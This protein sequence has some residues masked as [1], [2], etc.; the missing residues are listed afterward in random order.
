MNKIYRNI[1]AAASAL[2][3]LS[4]TGCVNEDSPCPDNDDPGQGMSIQFTVVTHNPGQGAGAQSQTDAPSAAPALNGASRADDCNGDQTGSPAENFIDMSTCQFFLFDGSGTV[5]RRIFPEETSKNETSY[6]WYQFKAE[7]VEPYFDNAIKSGKLTVDFYIMVIANSKSLDGQEIA[8]TPG[9]TT[10]ADIAA[11]RRTFVQPEGYNDPNHDYEFFPWEPDIANK[12]LI[13]MAGIQKFTVST[14]DLAASTYDTPVSLSPEMAGGIPVDAPKDI[15]MLRA[16]AKIEV[17]DKIDITGVYDPSID[18]NPDIP[19]YRKRPTVDKV[20]LYGYFQKGTLMPLIG[21]G[22]PWSESTAQVSV[23]TLPESP[24]YT[25][26][27]EY[28]QAKG[29]W[30][31]GVFTPMYDD[32]GNIMYDYYPSSPITFTY[33]EYATAQREDKCRVY[34]GYVVEYDRTLVPEYQ[35]DLAG[36]ERFPYIRVTVNNPGEATTNSSPVFTVNVAKYTDGK[37]GAGLEELL[38]NHIYRYELTGISSDVLNASWTICEW[39]SYDITIPP[40]N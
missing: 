40:I 12:R 20:E 2:M 7:I 26:P 5:L 15:Y 35:A 4:L 14:A 16:L 9:R 23:P 37:P 36:C 11:L 28:R 34:S 31:N 24:E 38:R 39:G 27:I 25:L 19:N 33:D 17:I 13:P 3:A 10:I 18:E 30:E 22:K 29:T 1:L 8:Y 21:A 32:D 6:Q